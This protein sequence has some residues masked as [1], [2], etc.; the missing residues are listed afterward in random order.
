LPPDPA[1]AEIE[2]LWLAVS[3]TAARSL[4][5]L[6]A[7]AGEGTTT[8]AEALTRRAAVGGRRTLYVDL[9]GAHAAGAGLGLAPDAI[10]PGAQDGVGVLANPSEASAHAWRDP[11]RLAAQAASWLEAWDLLI[12]D[13]APLLADVSSGV[14]PLSVATAAEATILVVLS[15]RT[16]A[17][18]V[19]DVQQRLERARARLIG[20]VLNDRDNPSLLAE[21]EREA[22]RLDRVAPGVSRRI[23]GALRRSSLLAQRT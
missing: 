5:I 4:A 14:P 10:L 7:R 2:S 15:G 19:R 22:G 12:L 8:L 18:D 21:L 13:C 16:P 9:S 3:G 20:T 17:S 6:A 23:R 11:A 1:D